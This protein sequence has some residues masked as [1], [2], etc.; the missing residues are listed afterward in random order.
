MARNELSLKDTLTNIE[1]I[2]KQ[3][4]AIQVPPEAPLAWGTLRDILTMSVLPLFRAMAD[5]IHERLEISESA[6]WEIAQ[7]NDAERD[8]ALSA[9][10]A[11]TITKFLDDAQELFKIVTDVRARG[12]SDR[13]DTLRDLVTSL[14][15]ADDDEEEDAADDEE[16]DEEED[17]GKGAAT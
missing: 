11:G 9:E 6:L 1:D 4:L 12:L 14:V 13:A 7:G 15:D 16:E 17:E 2:T 10:T 8:E 3:V 5:E